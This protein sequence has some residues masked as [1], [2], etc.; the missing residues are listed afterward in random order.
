[1]KYALFEQLKWNVCVV[2]SDKSDKIADVFEVTLIDQAIPVVVN[3]MSCATKLAKLVN[4][5]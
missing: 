3:V 1:M 5:T 2:L 4:N